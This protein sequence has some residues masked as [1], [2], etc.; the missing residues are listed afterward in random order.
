MGIEEL[1]EEAVQIQATVSEE[2]FA[3]FNEDQLWA[4]HQ[5]LN[6]ATK[7]LVKPL[8]LA[9]KALS[10]QFYNYGKKKYKWL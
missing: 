6:R 2:T 10:K 5:A 8:A 3:G 4:I 7:T 9:D 1:K